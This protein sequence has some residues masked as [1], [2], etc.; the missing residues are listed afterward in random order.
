MIHAHKAV[1]NVQTMPNI[2]VPRY[3]FTPL[4]DRSKKMPQFQLYFIR[5]PLPLWRGGSEVASVVA[6]VSQGN[7]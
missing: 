1:A 6:A 3:V 4:G 7:F 5:G 2:S